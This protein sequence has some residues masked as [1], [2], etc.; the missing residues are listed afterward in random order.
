MKASMVKEALQ[1]AIK[2][3]VHNR[4]QIIHHSDRG[5]QYCC[6]EYAEFAVKSKFQLSTAEKSDPYENAVADRINGI[7]K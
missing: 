7:L 1:M 6:P 3:C 2:N 5:I 4:K